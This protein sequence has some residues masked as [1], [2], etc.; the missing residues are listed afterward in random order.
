M[1]AKMGVHV[2]QPDDLSTQ[3]TLCGTSPV[4]QFVWRKTG[5]HDL[6]I[7]EIRV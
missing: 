3:M 7:K 6:G 2:S 4:N 5:E 1:M